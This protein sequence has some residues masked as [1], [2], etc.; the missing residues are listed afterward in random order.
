MLT[1]G[2]S[3]QSDVLS[4]RSLFTGIMFNGDFAPMT[5]KTITLLVGAQTNRQDL[6]SSLIS[7]ITI[8]DVKLP[9][10]ADDEYVVQ[11]FPDQNI[12]KI[13][14]KK[15]LDLIS[16]IKLY[17]FF[18][19]EIRTSYDAKFFN[20]TNEIILNLPEILSQVIFVR[21]KSSLHNLSYKILWVKNN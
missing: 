11:S 15:D 10:I 8:N 5:T 13:F 6:A 3:L 9:N 20:Q 12:I 18:G 16:E 17:D 14:A 4:D 21:I 1:S 19:N 7:A 2:T